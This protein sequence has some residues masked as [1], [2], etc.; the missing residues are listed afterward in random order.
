VERRFTF[1][2]AASVIANPETGII[3]VRATSRQHEKVQEFIDQV[4]GSAKRQVLIEATIVEV[5]LSDQYQAGV[6]WSRIAQNGSG[7]TF[8]QTFSTGVTGSAN[9]TPPAILKYV[10]SSGNLSGA[11]SLLTEFGDTKVLSSPK[12]MALNNQTALLKVV[13]EKVYFTIDVRITD[14]SQTGPGRTDFVSQVKSVPVGLVMS[15][16]PQISDNDQVSLNVRPSVS[17]IT[18]FVTDPNPALA[19]AK[20]TSR[21]PEIQVRE[22][23]SILRVPS[24]QTV[25]LGGLMQDNQAIKRDGVP[26]LSKLPVI[27]DAFTY[28]NDTSGKTELVIFLRPIVVREANLGNTLDNYRGLLPDDTFFRPSTAPSADTPREAGGNRP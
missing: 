18:G 7:F 2:E 6:D 1:R 21:I 28:R 13:D 10:N 14:A 23:E 24:G 11:I 20:V 4:I 17:R 19:A 8:A 5:T 27:G 15:V 9:G 26:F 3:S 16:T 22:L 12:I 25:V